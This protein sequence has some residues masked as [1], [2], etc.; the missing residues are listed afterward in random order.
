MKIKKQYL[1]I[2]F[3][4]LACVIM[5]YVDAILQPGYVYKSIIKILLFVSL[6]FLYSLIDKQYSMM[7][8]LKIK[9]NGLLVPILIGIGIYV[10][11][12]GA[13]LIFKDIF[14]FSSLTTSLNQ[15][16]GV[17]ANNFVYVAMYISVV[18][19][20]LEEFFFRGFAFL[21]LKKFASKRFAYLFSSLM[22]AFYHVAMM[23]GWY[24]CIVIG[25]CLIGLMIGGCIF[26]YF[27]E[28]GNSIYLSWLI[29]MFAN[30]ATNTIGFMLFY[31]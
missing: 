23:I 6:P 14:D 26:N 10:V 27:D 22:F 11:I 19:S 1:V 28:Q 24:D 29:H 20:F 25:L 3:V 7:D 9:S 30:L 13:Y 8:G 2:G 16:T 5:G 15:S 17:N 12:V 31:L 21:T 18:N 4:I